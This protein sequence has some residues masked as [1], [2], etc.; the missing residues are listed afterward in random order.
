M[1][2]EDL[3]NI[4]IVSVV[5]PFLLAVLL[6][7]F[8]ISFQRR[9]HIYETEKKNAE[10]REKELI[11]KNQQ[12]IVEERTRIATEMHDELGSGLTIIKYL[13]ESLNV[14]CI[15]T[16]QKQE[17]EK[18]QKY[19]HQ[20][21][22]NMSDIIW[23]MNHRF[24]NVENLIGFLRRNVSEFLEDSH[25]RHK[26]TILGDG[27]FK[28][29]GGEKRR[30][31]YLI[32]KEWLNNAVKYSDAQ[33]V[34]L[35]IEA[36]ENLTISFFEKGGKGFDLEQQIDDGNGL[37]NIQKR[38]EQIGANISYLKSSDGML[39]TLIVPLDEIGTTLKD[40]LHKT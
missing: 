16:E 13:S 34:E 25:I 26:I 3:T 37:Y 7:W 2:E 18:I 8:F 5:M 23:A 14:Q 40:I 17:L 10:L 22:H 12:N 36:G 29:L 4:I 6:V 33:E 1:F 15:D 27:T 30:N 38:A 19:S 32:I 9:R 35:K 39:S 31:I 20:L 11:I 24:D 21:V 28:P